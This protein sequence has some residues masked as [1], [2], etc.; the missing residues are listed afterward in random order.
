MNKK[1]TYRLKTFLCVAVAFLLHQNVNAQLKSDFSADTTKGCGAVTVNFQNNSSGTNFTSKWE[2][3]NGNSSSQTSPSANYTSPGKYTVRL[4]INDGINSDTLTRV[5]FIEVFR[6]PV[7]DFSGSPLSGCAPLSVAF[8]DQSTLGDAPIA[9][10]IWDF[11]DGNDPSNQQNPSH[12]YLTGGSYLPSLQIIDQNGCDA[13]NTPVNVNVTPTPEA[14]FSTSNSRVN[15]VAPYTVN[16]VNQSKGNNLSYFWDFGD[17]NTSSATNPSHTYSAFGKYD[18][19]LI[20]KDPACQDTLFSQAYVRLETSNAA[21]S[22]PK[23]EFCTGEKIQFTNTSTGAN[24][25]RWN[26]G[27]QSS[28]LDKNPTKNYTDSGWFNVSLIISVGNSC[29]S[30]VKDSI[31]I[32]Q[33]IA[34]F[35]TDSVYSCN[36]NDTI[37]F[38]NKSTNADRYRWIIGEDKSTK[39]YFE[40]N[41]IHKQNTI[42]DSASYTDTLIVA[43]NL[44]CIDTLVKKDN[45]QFQALRT[46]IILDTNGNSPIYDTIGSCLPISY[47][48]S[49]ISYGALPV[50]SWLWQFGDG[51]SSS[52][53]NPTITYR[54]DSAYNLSITV[55]N[56]LGCTASDGVVV[57][58]G[59]KQDPTFSVS[60]DSVCQGDSVRISID[61]FDTLKIDFFTVDIFNST[62]S[63][64]SAS[65]TSFA[66][67]NTFQDTG[68]MDVKVTVFN[69]DCDSTLGLSNLVYVKGPIIKPQ[70]AA[71]G[72]C[73]NRRSV[74][75]TGGLRG[76]T[77]FYWNFG[78]GSPVD[79]V[80]ENPTH[81][82][83]SPGR[84]FARLTAYN[85]INDCGPQSDSLFI[86]IK[87]TL[88][89]KLDP[90]T[91][92]C[93]GD[94]VKYQIAF[95]DNFKEVRWFM[96]NQLINVGA[97][98]DT[99]LDKR[100]FYP[101]KLRTIDNFSCK[102]SLLDTILISQPRAKI[103]IKT[104]D[105]CKP[106]R[107]AF[108]DS[109]GRDTTINK[110][111]WIFNDTLFSYQS[112]D[113]L[114]FNVNGGQDVF[115]KVTNIFGCS[116]SIKVKNIIEIQN[117][118]VNYSVPRLNICV[119]DS[120]TFTNTSSGVNVNYQWD[121]GE[122]PIRMDNS[123]RVGH[124]F[125]QA[126]LF[127]IKLIGNDALG[128][129][130]V[131]SSAIVNVQAIPTAD[132]N[133]N[134]RS[135]NCYPLGVRF[136]DLSSPTV[137]NWNW[138]FGDATGSVLQDPFHNYVTNGKF[139]VRLRVTT[140][141]GCA[142]DTIKPQ[143][144]ETSG[145]S[146]N[147]S[148]DKDTVCIGELVSF[149][150]LNPQNY[151]SISIDFGDGNSTSALNSTHRYDTTGI[152]F[153]SLNMTQASTNCKVTIRDTLYIF[154]VK[155]RISVKPLSGCTPIT[156][157]LVNKSEG[158][159]SYLWI[160]NNNTG[161]ALDSFETSFN[162]AGIYPIQLII[163]SPEGCKDT[164][165]KDIEVFPLPDIVAIKDTGLCIGDS[166]EL[167]ASGGI[168]YQWNPI[169]FLSTPKSART[170]AFPD[171]STLYSVNVT[172]SKGCKASV[173]VHVDVQQVPSPSFLKDTN[174]IIGER[175]QLNARAG[176]NLIYR[177]R[178]PDGLSCTNCSDPIA[179]PLNT[180][181][182][183]VNISDPLG[184][185]SVQDSILIEVKEAY[186]LDVP[187]G[188]SPNNDG[189]NDVIYA[190]GWGLKELIAF[191]IYN[192][193]GEMVFES[194]DF[195]VGWDG[196]YKNELQNIET[197]VY[198]VEALTYGD[199]V[200]SKKGNISLLR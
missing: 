109:S 66:Y 35:E 87:D 94:S 146:A 141:N 3:G 187:N 91:N 95:K 73:E 135:S 100:G 191:R 62:G 8:T 59:S 199:E 28:S 117:L 93:L 156:S 126:G 50:K 70:F 116:D 120:I 133:A 38:L 106:V 188:F 151:S 57:L 157:T 142:H 45:R 7:S 171:T 140:A 136:E 119:G 26:F 131:D 179:Q 112:N 84:Y 189:V 152:L 67:I 184:C 18:V 104:L 162:Q 60:P 13:V 44:G 170:L 163:D 27:D 5:D 194:T 11:S 80:N 12:V 83:P 197:Y 39:A 1:Q 153:P 107:I 103:A 98:F 200:I 54:G 4:I 43:S 56:S 148:I 51:T 147:F 71:S 53:P 15:C 139:D 85:D 124:R 190:K 181:R 78:D 183:Y 97:K 186:S 114:T 138:D 105:Q 128:C 9:T 101:I 19:S 21:F 52:S 185:F 48:L 130:K 82:Y 173:Q 79:S 22:L 122:G 23:K 40:E 166:I 49:D 77:R 86:N 123:N 145:P 159:S 30:S 88:P 34:D 36:L 155:A 137:V 33:I 64:T 96:N 41:P 47:E 68:W 10:Y 108:I 149:Q 154:D 160:V 198:T 176:F 74:R 58:G 46:I 192:R 113:T 168:D 99:L 134:P 24:I 76:V 115:L 158:Y 2:F 111:K 65:Y 180:T 75:F 177:W 143:F 20:T 110:W 144:I 167:F 37:R 89:V 31:Y 42:K 16:F 178:P 161:P 90:D 150:V 196:K 81:V 32:Q 175:L 182:Y 164:I 132:F 125:Q 121:F 55:T 165:N 102:D 169:E 17:G 129:S 118:R 29:I 193:F 72:K 6:N 92:Y 127:K 174:L 63:N 69:N 25:Y 14:A 172:D 61:G 195:N